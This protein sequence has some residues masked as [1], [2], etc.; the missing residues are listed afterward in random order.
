MWIGLAAALLAAGCQ[1]EAPGA[2]K[3]LEDQAQEHARKKQ[4]QEQAEAQ[5]KKE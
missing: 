1:N 4:A 2:A 3:K 5:R